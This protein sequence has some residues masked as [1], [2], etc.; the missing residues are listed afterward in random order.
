MTSFAGGIIN[1]TA[2]VARASNSTAGRVLGDTVSNM[3]VEAQSRQNGS[4]VFATAGPTLADAAGAVV[5][6]RS[7]SAVN[8]APNAASVGS[9]GGQLAG[10]YWWS[11][12]RGYLLFS[13]GGY[14][15]VCNGFGRSEGKWS[16]AGTTVTMQFKER[17]GTLTTTTAESKSDVMDGISKY[18][19]GRGPFKATMGTP[20]KKQFEANCPR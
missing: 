9:G 4:K 3:L 1:P 11:A 15:A 17:D 5:L 13:G 19:N 20:Y 12:E 6:G 16:Q 14:V 7:S 2:N 8:S 18:G 10:T